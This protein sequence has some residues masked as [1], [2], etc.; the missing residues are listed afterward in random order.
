MAV[1]GPGP[2]GQQSPATTVQLLLGALGFFMYKLAIFGVAVL[3]PPDKAA[4]Y[5]HRDR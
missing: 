5:L 4:S 2:H 1:P 3:P